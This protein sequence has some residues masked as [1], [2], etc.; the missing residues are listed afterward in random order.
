MSRQLTANTLRQIKD[1]AT[2]HVDTRDIARHV[3]LSVSTIYK[4]RQGHYDGVLQPAAVAEAPRRRKKITWCQRCR[5]HC[6]GPCKVCTLRRG[7]KRP[8]GRP[9]A[10]IPPGI[11]DPDVLRKLHLPLS[12]LALSIRTVNRLEDHNILDV[13]DLLH[14]TRQELLKIPHVGEQAL[15]QIFGALARLGFRR[16][17]APPPLAP[18]QPA[19]EQPASEQPAAT[20]PPCV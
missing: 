11:T 5:C 8:A 10:L 13:N 7:G 6:E 3:G 12:Q 16:R 15:E 17:A 9:R 19:S 2:R 4:A 1:L 18:K 14:C 20:E